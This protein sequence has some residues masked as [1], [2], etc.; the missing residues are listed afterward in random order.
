VHP[1]V[2]KASAGP[3]PIKSST[4]EILYDDTT[5][6]PMLW[7]LT[8][9]TTTA[10]ATLAALITGLGACVAPISDRTHDDFGADAG[11]TSTQTGCDNYKIVTMDLTVSGAASFNNLPTTCW[12]L[13]GKLTVTGPAVTSLAKLGDLREVSDLEVD[14]SA[15]TKFDS[16]GPIDVS[17]DIYIH[18][19]SSLTDLT[20]V[21]AKTQVNSVR[22]EYNPV[23]TNFGGV[24]RAS[25]VAGATTIQDNVKLTTIDLSSAQRLEGGVTIT[26]NTVLT[27]IQ[28]TALQSVGGVTI[29]RNPA[30]TNLSNMSAMTNIHGAFTLDNNNALVTLGTFGTSI[31]VDTNISITNNA[32]LADTGAILHATRVFGT[33]AINYNAALDVTKAHDIGC[34]VPTGAFGATGNKTTQCA[35]NHYCLQSSGGALQNCLK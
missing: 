12:K 6:R 16:K 4:T 21:V 10:L 2:D 32:K 26:D 1:S 29:S 27:T 35:G 23:L 20:N 24:G 18:N 13:S 34:C 8:M 33:V 28:L 15:L 5:A 17:H 9:R 3:T 31:T 25:V 14:E 22:V 19:N 30:L 11:V 7:R